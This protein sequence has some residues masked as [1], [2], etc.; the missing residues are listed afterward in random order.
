VRDASDQTGLPISPLP[1]LGA[2]ASEIA[3]REVRAVL[4]DPNAN[5]R[6]LMR[7][8]LWS[9]G[10]HDVIPCRYLDEVPEILEEEDVDLILISLDG[11]SEDACEAVRD[12]RHN[13]L[14]SNPFVVVMA[15]TWHPDW[16]VAVPTIN[17]GTDDLVAKPVSVQTLLDRIGNLVFHRKNFVV[18]M[19]YVG[20]DRRSADRQSPDEL[21][22]IKVPNT[23]RYK[24][25]R[26]EAASADDGAIERAMHTIQTHRVYRIACRLAAGVHQ[27]ETDLAAGHGAVSTPKLRELAVLVAMVKDHIA[28]EHLEQLS[29]IGHSMGEVMDAV[30]RL[31]TPTVRDLEILRLHGHAVA[32]AIQEKDEAAALLATALDKAAKLVKRSLHQPMDRREEIQ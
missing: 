17:A 10:I 27:F 1:P 14:G 12:I 30:L 26:D 20:P 6:N 24:V 19:S 25:T 18:T 7:S 32:A 11:D 8:A 15:F 22:T 13:R 21:P 2:M 23:L 31:E 28:R 29:R 5:V 16:E 3:L 9:I 4:V